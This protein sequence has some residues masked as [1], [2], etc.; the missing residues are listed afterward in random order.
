MNKIVTLYIF[1][2]LLPTLVFSYEYITAGVER[3]VDGD[4]FIIKID[5]N[6]KT[7]KIWGVE[8][9]ERRQYYG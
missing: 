4:T 6:V 5:D 2:L 3:I 1:F 9:L 7:V 8:A